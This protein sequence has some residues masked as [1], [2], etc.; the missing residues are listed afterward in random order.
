MT[1]QAIR[2]PTESCPYGNKGH[3]RMPRRTVITI[4]NYG[5]FD[6]FTIGGWTKDGEGRIEFGGPIVKGSHAFAF[7]NATVISAHAQAEETKIALSVGDEVDLHGDTYRIEWNQRDRRPS[8][9]F[10]PMA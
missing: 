10:I 1:A 5:T 7:P 2:V 9:K 3:Y 4:R 8:L 6:T